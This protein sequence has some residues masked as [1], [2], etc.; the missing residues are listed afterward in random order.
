ECEETEVDQ[1][2]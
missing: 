1:H 2:V